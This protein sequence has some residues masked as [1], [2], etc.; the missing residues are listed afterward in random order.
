MKKKDYVK[1]KKK[2]KRIDSVLTSLSRVQ[3]S[4]GEATEDN[5]GVSSSYFRNI[6]LTFCHTSSGGNI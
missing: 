6:M 3:R 1:M 4:Q 5:Q 2:N